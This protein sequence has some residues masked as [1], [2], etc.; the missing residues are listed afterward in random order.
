M[1][2]KNKILWND[3]PWWVKVPVVV[4]WVQVVGF[5]IGLLLGL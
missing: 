4:G 5:V 3:L 2:E 1:V